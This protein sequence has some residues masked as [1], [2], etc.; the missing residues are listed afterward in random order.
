[1]N[2]INGIRIC[3]RRSSRIG[4]T[5]ASNV[6]ERFDQY[7]HVQLVTTTSKTTLRYCSEM[8]HSQTIL[9]SYLLWAIGRFNDKSIDARLSSSFA[10]MLSVDYSI[11]IHRTLNRRT[12]FPR[13]TIYF[14]LHHSFLC[15]SAFTPKYIFFNINRLARH[16]Y[17]IVT[18]ITPF[19]GKR[20][21]VLSISLPRIRMEIY[22]I[23]CEWNK[24][25]YDV[26]RLGH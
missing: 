3:A 11:T 20:S 2:P 10:H 26:Y 23:C 14:K 1:M 13:I 24:N 17:H 18:S 9:Q 5:N 4:M 21:K 16:I 7:V 25:D 6:L 12:Y 19:L 8:S 15:V 22:A